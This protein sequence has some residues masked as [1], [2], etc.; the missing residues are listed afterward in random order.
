M[1]QKNYLILLL[2]FPLI[3]IISSSYVTIPFQILGKNEPLR[4]SSIEDYFT[5]N[6]DVEFYSEISIGESSTQIPL[7][8]TF[9]DY[10]LYFIS[11]GTEMGNLNNIYEPSLS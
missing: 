2:L 3:N 6:S 8:L 5:Y 11:K 7:L 10:G 1:F 4:Y 9:N